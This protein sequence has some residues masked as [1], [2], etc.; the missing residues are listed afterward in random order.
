MKSWDQKMFQKIGDAARKQSP[1][2]QRWKDQLVSLDGTGKYIVRRS[3]HD[4]DDWDQDEY[5]RMKENV[6]SVRCS[7]CGTVFR[8]G[9]TRC[10]C[11]K[12]QVKAISSGKA[13]Q[14]A[15][16]E[17]CPDCG[18]LPVLTSLGNYAKTHTPN[19]RSFRKAL[20]LLGH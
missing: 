9:S 18:A 10:L 20:N 13:K 17:P 12:K 14:Y 7:K 11:R 6:D 8:L 5:R 4:H 1:E 16:V 2:Y 15:Q 19:C 3:R